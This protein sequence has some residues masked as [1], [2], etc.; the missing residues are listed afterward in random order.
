MYY[1]RSKLE[2]VFNENNISDVVDYIYN[3]DTNNYKQMKKL[4]TWFIDNWFQ[5]DVGIGVS[6]SEKH[7]LNPIFRAMSEV[8]PEED[9]D[10]ANYAPLHRG[11]V[12]KSFQQKLSVFLFDVPHTGCVNLGKYRGLLFQ[13]YLKEFKGDVVATEKFLNNAERIKIPDSLVKLDFIQDIAK[14]AYGTR[15]WSL[16]KGTA[17]HWGWERPT[18]AG[19][20]IDGFV[21]IYMKPT[22]KELL[23]SVNGYMHHYE[24]VSNGREIP[25]F[26][27][28]EAI[29]SIEDLKV[30]SLYLFPGENQCR[31]E[32]ILSK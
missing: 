30:H 21:F 9:E 13:A 15:S 31:Y 22:P 14:L 8:F 6:S 20:H 27:W 24:D 7:K 5:V 23:F 29:L 32:V 26:D 12:S 1:R 19:S 11:R 25:G 18:A 16:D 17:M 10:W 2:K 4:N 28:D 3:M